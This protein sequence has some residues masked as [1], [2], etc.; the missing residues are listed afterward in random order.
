IDSTGHV[1]I[2]ARVS[3]AGTDTTGLY[4]LIKYSPNGVR[5]WVASQL[6]L[7]LGWEMI[8]LDVDSQ[9]NAY[10]LTSNPTDTELHP[11]SSVRFGL[12]TS[13]YNAAG[14]QEWAAREYGD[15]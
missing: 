9:G 10:V 11:Y 12:Q 14:E 4:F 3:T 13:K 7:D 5:Q 8:A 6:R 15:H 1:Y 2:L